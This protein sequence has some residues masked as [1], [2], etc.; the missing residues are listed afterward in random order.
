VKKTLFLVPFVYFSVASNKVLLDAKWVW[1]PSSEAAIT[2]LQSK[3]GNPPKFQAM[4][5]SFIQ[6]ATRK[7]QGPPGACFRPAVRK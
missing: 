1:A 6:F 5:I 3:M 2:H 7:L 4:A